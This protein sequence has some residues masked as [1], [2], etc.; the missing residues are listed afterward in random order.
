MQSCPWANHRP[1]RCFPR[2]GSAFPISE[3]IIFVL[4]P[5][6]GWEWMAAGTFSETHSGRFGDLK[7]SA[8]SVCRDPDESFWLNWWLFR[9]LSLGKLYFYSLKQQNQGSISMSCWRACCARPLDLAF[10][11]LTPLEGYLSW[12]V[13][14]G[15]CM[16]KRAL[17]KKQGTSLSLFFPFFFIPKRFNSPRQ[18]S[19]SG[20]PPL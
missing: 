18:K 12:R 9:A 19:E 6:A 3:F 4:S 1:L 17:N 14:A 15:G 2:K 11:Q 7:Q 20:P 5:Q 8:A 10:T 13:F 16:N